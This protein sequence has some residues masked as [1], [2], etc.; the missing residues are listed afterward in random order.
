[1]Y[2]TVKSLT[3]FLIDPHKSPSAVT[4]AITLALSNSGQLRSSHST[5]HWINVLLHPLVNTM[6]TSPAMTARK[7][8]AAAF[9]VASSAEKMAVSVRLYSEVFVKHTSLCRFA[10]VMYLYI[11]I[12]DFLTQEIKG[13]AKF[14]CNS[15]DCKFEEPAMNDLI[16]QIFGDAYISVRCDGGE[17]L[18]FSQVPGYV[19]R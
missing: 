3:C 2:K 11:D 17:C 10:H 14:S 16:N 18:H 1:M 15:G 9:Q 6:A 7:S 4:T 5:A 13:P 19:V 8:S 12:G